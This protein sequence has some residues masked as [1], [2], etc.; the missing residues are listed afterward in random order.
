M[1]IRK[2]WRALRRYLIGVQVALT[3]PRT[4]Q[5]IRHVLRQGWTYLD[6][7]ALYEVAQQIVKLE[8]TQQS[9]ILIEA[10]CALGGSALVIAQAKARQRPFYLYDAFG[11]IP[12]PSTH[13]EA[14]AHQRY[15]EIAAG[16][17]QGIN[18]QAYYGYES[19]LQ[20]KV[21]ANFVTCGL[22]PAAHAVHFVPGFY[23]KTLWV[24]QP[25]AFA[26]LDCDWHD[27]VLICLQR[28]TPH[29]VPGGVLIIDDYNDWSGC[30]RAV[31]TY[32]A[33]LKTQFIFTMGERLHICKK[34]GC[35]GRDTD[36]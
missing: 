13:D 11:M 21:R 1:K 9:G 10:G 32:F 20:V 29:L 8:G 36:R 25:V 15:A 22:E 28:I 16:R 24:D 5:M 26:H 30:K 19:N 4:V 27:S 33:A 6:E 14:D 35:N 34:Q 2:L 18:G 12:P 31:D 3:T 23:E 17:A 7:A